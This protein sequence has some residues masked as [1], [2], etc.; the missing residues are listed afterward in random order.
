[1]KPNARELMNDSRR[2]EAK[3]NL[4]GRSTE[5]LFW[6]RERTHFF[7]GF[8]AFPTGPSDKDRVKIKT[9]R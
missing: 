6:S 4:C 9:L 7:E 1:M 5:N 3:R 8:Q 2:V